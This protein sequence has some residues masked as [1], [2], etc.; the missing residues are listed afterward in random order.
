MKRFITVSLIIVILILQ[1][2][3]QMNSLP[4]SLSYDQALNI[5]LENNPE[6]KIRDLNYTISQEQLSESKLKRAPQIYGRY[7][8]QRNLVIPTTLVPLGEFIPG[9]NSEELTPIKFGTNWYSGAGI[10]G[11]VKIFDPS[12]SGEIREKK[13]LLALS[14]VDRQIRKID[15]LTETGKA[16]INSILALEQLKFAVEDTLN[17]RI[18][19]DET[20]LKYEKGLL[21]LTD[22]N[23][24]R[25]DMNIA[26]SRYSESEKIYSE[27]LKILI[28]WMG[29]SQEAGTDFILTDTLDLL[30]E[31][32]GI[33]GE[34]STKF[35]NSLTYKRNQMQD[36]LN[37]IRLKNTKSEFLP[38]VS[39]N[40]YYSGDYY[41]NQLH[42]SDGRYWFGNSSVNLSVRIPLTEGIDRTKKIS[43]YKYQME[44]DE[45][46][47][48]SELNQKSLGI[49]KAVDDLVFFRKE[50]VRKKE[51][52]V[53]TRA[54]YKTAFALFQSGRLLPSELSEADLSYKKA[55]VDYLNTVY[56]YL[57]ALLELKRIRES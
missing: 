54:N 30:M 49:R 7:D 3:A 51:N 36:Q 48:A 33:V 20:R 14:D 19:F 10:Y 40:G 5:S 45:A 50:T 18:R 47:F 41:Q 1:T 4:S 29:F 25:L 31:K 55:R 21:K 9:S 27:T 44:A 32:L 46:F 17:G 26:A 56:S 39:L 57:N 16:Y 11:S 23:Q 2:E 6:N 24:S 53:L 28:Y 34:N 38:V 52:I 42:I 15:L 35:E 43:Q 13:A 12:L 22:L 37:R 8:I